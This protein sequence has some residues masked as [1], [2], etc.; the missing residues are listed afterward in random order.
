[1][2]EASE[3]VGG[4]IP[5]DIGVAEAESGT[6]GVLEVGL[7]VSWGVVGRAV[8][9]GEVVV[10]PVTAAGFSIGAIVLTTSKSRSRSAR[11]VAFVF[12]TA[13]P[14]DRFVGNNT[15][16]SQSPVIFE[17]ITRPCSVLTVS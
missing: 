11:S 6:E 13:I 10:G 14:N 12:T 17:I 5:G 4:D 7:T 16:S 2:I 8:S 1:M 9:T 15:A 3:E